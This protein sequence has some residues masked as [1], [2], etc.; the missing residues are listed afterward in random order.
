MKII[1]STIIEIGAL[2]ALFL[3]FVYFFAEK[4]IF[5]APSA[6]Y[7][8]SGDI[9]HIPLPGGGALSGGTAAGG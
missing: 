4:I 8:D 2:Y 7:S 6:S 3:L 1:I 5:P 9:L